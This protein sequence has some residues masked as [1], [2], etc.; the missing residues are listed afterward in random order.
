[1]IRTRDVIFDEKSK[2]DSLDIDLIQIIIELMLET[3]FEFQNLDSIINIVEVNIWENDTIEKLI[4]SFIE[5]ETDQINQ[6]T[7]QLKDKD[8]EMKYL[9]SSSSSN[10]S[11]SR[12]LDVST[13]SKTSSTKEIK[14][15]KKMIELDIDT[16]N[17]ISER[18]R[19][20]RATRK[21]TYLIVLKEIAEYEITSFLIA[22]WAM[23]CA[24]AFY[25]HQNQ[26]ATKLLTKL[27]L[28]SFHRNSLSLE[29]KNFR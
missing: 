22:F 8:K 4:H 18:M 5:D 19:R 13:T 23:S 16:I 25:N 26:S 11:T 24:S 1:M 27:N 3:T 6:N 9:L 14:I 12:Q 20:R 10:V 17:I 28:T 15:K 21:Q 29:S 2:Y 7:S